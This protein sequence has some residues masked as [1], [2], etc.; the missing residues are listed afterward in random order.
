MMLSRSFIVAVFILC[1]ACGSGTQDAENADTTITSSQPADKDVV[2]TTKPLISGELYSEP[3]FKSKSLVQ[4]DT[5]QYVYLLEKNG[6]VFVKARI[7]K[8]DQTYIGYVS[9]AILPE[10]QL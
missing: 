4:F 9:K 8:N 2:A 3:D 7:I 5:A 6:E 10:K 1:S